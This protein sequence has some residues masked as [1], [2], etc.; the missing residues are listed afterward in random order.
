MQADKIPRINGRDIYECANQLEGYVDPGTPE[1][2]AQFLLREGKAAADLADEIVRL[3]GQVETL[4]AENLEQAR[5]LGV[6]GERELQ[7]LAER[8][9]LREAQNRVTDL[10]ES[11]DTRFA[12]RHTIPEREIGILDT[13]QNIRMALAGTHD[14]AALQKEPQ[15]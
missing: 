8:D 9:R 15:P 14:P 7:L 4:T 3:Q 2:L 6:G 11:Y 12:P 5:L 13:C 1:R 10:L